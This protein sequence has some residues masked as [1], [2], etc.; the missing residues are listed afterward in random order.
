VWKNSLDFPP[1]RHVLTGGCRHINGV[2]GLLMETYTIIPG[3]GLYT[4]SATSEGGT[5]RVVAAFP[6]EQVATDYLRSLQQEA[7]ASALLAPPSQ[8]RRS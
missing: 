5:R 4:I 3:R 2:G 1:P 8:G 7:E 6:S